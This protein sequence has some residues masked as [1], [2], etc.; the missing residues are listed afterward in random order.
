[1]EGEATVSK[2]GS[3]I[4]VPEKLLREVVDEMAWSSTILALHMP[5][6]VLSH[7]KKLACDLR[8]I[9]DDASKPKRGRRKARNE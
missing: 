9:L 1:M 4:L 3:D 5:K 8:R 2:P 7:G 6:T